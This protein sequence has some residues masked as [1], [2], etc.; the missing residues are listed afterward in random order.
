LIGNA[1]GGRSKCHPSIVRDRTR[2]ED[3]DSWSSRD[4]GGTQRAHFDWNEPSEKVGE[5]LDR[6]RRRLQL[7]GDRRTA[8]FVR[9]LRDEDV[10]KEAWKFRGQAFDNG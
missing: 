8:S 6:G 2:H 10:S 1:A 4:L 9:N 7:Q 3:V 5:G